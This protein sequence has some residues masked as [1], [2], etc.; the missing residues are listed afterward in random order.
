MVHRQVLHNDLPQADMDRYENEVFV[1]TIIL[2]SV[3]RW[4]LEAY[5]E[6][7]AVKYKKLTEYVPADTH[8]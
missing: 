3:A 2:M 6:P 1:V 4:T 7:G 5:L 8:C